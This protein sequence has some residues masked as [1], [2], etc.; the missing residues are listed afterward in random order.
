MSESKNEKFKRLAEKRTNYVIDKLR[1]IGNLS[2]KSLYDYSKYDVDAMFNAIEKSLKQSRN[3]F[4][5]AISKDN[6]FYFKN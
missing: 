6:K 5:D 4:S 2:N 1:L 3:E